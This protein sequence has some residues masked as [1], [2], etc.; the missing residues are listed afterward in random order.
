MNQH[1]CCAYPSCFGNGEESLQET[2]LA[3]LLQLVP[4]EASKD[5]LPIK[6]R[7]RQASPSD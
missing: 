1:Q 5:C 6:N 7:P 2:S 3:S 4:L